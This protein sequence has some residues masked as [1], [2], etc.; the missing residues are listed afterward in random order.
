MHQTKDEV[1][2]EEKG[3]LETT[4]VNVPKVTQSLTCR[5]VMTM[6]TTVTILLLRPLVLVPNFKMMTKDVESF[7]QLSVEMLYLVQS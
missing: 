5:K 1:P 7:G 4:A 3:D 2:T 6:M